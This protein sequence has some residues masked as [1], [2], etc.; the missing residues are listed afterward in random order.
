MRHSLLN[1]KAYKVVGY[2]LIIGI[3]ILLILPW[4]NQKQLAY[5]GTGLYLFMLGDWICTFL[6]HH[7]RGVVSGLIVGYIL[8]LVACILLLFYIALLGA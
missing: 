5:W 2:G 8:S 3:I 1:H 6:Q 4:I 7:G